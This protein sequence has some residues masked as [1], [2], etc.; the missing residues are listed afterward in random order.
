MFKVLK[1]CA[2]ILLYDG[3]FRSS[4]NI[5]R[6]ILVNVGDELCSI[7]EGDIFGKRKN[8][9]NARD[10]FK[11]WFSQNSEEGKKLVQGLIAEF[12]LS[13][14]T[15]IIQDKMIALGFGIHIPELKKRLLSYESIVF[16]EL[17]VDL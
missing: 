6:N 1:E 7:D 10:W 13:E 12:N 3:I 8:I 17:G 11:N 16:G 14:K 5:L 2:R 15:A 9:F 4:D